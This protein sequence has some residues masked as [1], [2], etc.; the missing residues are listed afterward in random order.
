MKNAIITILVILVLGL[1]GFILYDK[2]LKEDKSI[3][4][5]EKEQTQKEENADLAY[6]NYIKN[7]KNSRNSLKNN[8]FR[9]EVNS[10]GNPDAYSYIFTIDQ[11]G[12]LL[13]NLYESDIYNDYKI[14][15]NVLSAFIVNVGQYTYHDLYFIK[16]D[17]HLYNFGIDSF[18]QNGKLNITKVNKNNIVNVVTGS[19]SYDGITG[20]ME[21]I[22]IDVEGNIS[23]EE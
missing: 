14:S 20:T 7:L 6:K 23:Y 13:F 15:S 5:E 22:F 17:G 12:D 11:N 19:V 18:I 4:T 21:P 2:V 10:D 16:E 8:S 3:K 9:Y 1:G